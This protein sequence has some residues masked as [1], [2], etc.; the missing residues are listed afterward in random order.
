MI[1]GTQLEKS[2]F[3]RINNIMLSI[4]SLGSN[5]YDI[6]EASGNIPVK[7]HSRRW[8]GEKQVET[9][10]LCWNCEFCPTNEVFKAEQVMEKFLKINI[11][12]F[13]GIQNSHEICRD[14]QKK[15]RNRS[16][17]KFQTLYKYILQESLLC[18]ILCQLSFSKGKW[19]EKEWN[20]NVGSS[21]AG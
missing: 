18:I 5:V 8:R 13:R 16:S 12:H 10:K 20:K 1:N 19:S 14:Q 21:M 4:F 6:H 9:S 11:N 2:C 15:I 7:L 17:W 3:R